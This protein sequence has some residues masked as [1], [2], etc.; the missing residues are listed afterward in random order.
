MRTCETL[1]DVTED[2]V[3]F[4]KT[5]WKQVLGPCDVGKMWLL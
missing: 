2:E 3:F 1:K 5:C 4:H